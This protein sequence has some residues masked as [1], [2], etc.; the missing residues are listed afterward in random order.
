[1]LLTDVDERK[2]AED[3]LRESERELRLTV[4]SIPG[5]VAAHTPDGQ[6][7]FVNRQLLDYFGTTLEELRHWD[8]GGI[9]H[10]DD[11][12]RAVELFTHS[13][14]S[15]DPFD[16]EVRSRRFDGVYRWLQ[17]R[18]LAL[19][20]SN[21]HIVRW[22]NLLNDIDE[23]K[24]AEEAL[25]TN[26]RDLKLIIDTIPALSLVGA[27][28]WSRRLLQPA[29]SRIRRSACRTGDGWGWTAA[30]HPDDLNGLTAIWQQVLSSE[31]PGEAEARLRRHDGEYRWFLVRAKPLRDETGRVFKWYGIN[32]DIEDRKRTEEELRR[33]E[34][35]LAQGQRLTLTGSLWWEVSTGEVIWSEETFRIM[36]VPKSTKPTVELALS[37][38]HPEDVGLARQ[39]IER[40]APDGVNMDFELRLLMSDG[41]V[42]Y[43][44]VVLHNIGRQ[45]DKPEF[46]GALTDITERKRTEA[47]LRRAYDHLTEAQRLSQTGSFTTDLEEGRTPLVRRVLPHLRVRAR[48]D[49]LD[50]ETREIVHPE[51]VASLRG[52][53]RAR[54]GWHEPRFLFPH[55]D[56]ARRREAFS[57]LR[58]PDR[59][60]ARVHRRPSGRD[61]EQGRRGGA[62]QGPLRARTCG[63]GHDPERVDRL[64]RPRGNQPL[65]GIITNAGT[66]LRM[67]DADSSGRRRRARNR[68]AHD[69]RWQP[70]LGCDHAIARAVQQ[71]G[72]HAGA[73]GSERGHA[74][75][76]CA[77]VE[78]PSETPRDP[79]VGARRR[80]ADRHRRSCPAPAGHPEPAPQRRPTR[81]PACTIDREQLLIRTER[82][83]GDRVRLTVRDAGVGLTPR[84]WTSCLMPSTRRKAAAWASG[85][86]VSRSIIERHHGR[87]WAEPNDGP[88]ATFSFSIPPVQRAFGTGASIMAAERRSAI[89]RYQSLIDGRGAWRILSTETSVRARRRMRHLMVKRSL[90]S[91]VDDDESVRES[92][93]DLLRQF[94]F[95]AQAFS[96]AEAFLASEFVSRDQLSHSRRRD[97]RHVGPRPATGTGTPAAGRF[98][99]CSS[100]RTATR[101]SVRACWR[102][103]PS[104]ACSSRSARRRCSTRSMRRLRM[105]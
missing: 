26:E 76:H 48:S 36:D 78:R 5:L 99:L 81:W 34:A 88:G 87:L 57:W 92:L 75:G 28:R 90:V 89:T 71:D 19:R 80:S 37:R 51:D 104:S 63:E 49:D 58:A 56:L 91:V 86:S 17:S 95:A 83:D 2:R 68:A 66:C 25:A 30:I 13:I 42:K 73:A 53:D 93:P 40:S 94:G 3:A 41:S 98:R 43:V 69:S 8:T 21:G 44:H 7:E 33:S 103:G 54:H 39:I 46:I 96:S 9:T 12:P 64:D 100:P 45:P 38:V 102:R 101:R 77:V 74:R 59:R 15:G 60:T 16:F 70:R 32:I 65:S 20:D 6:V 14:E 97:A 11:L 18:G 67:L 55:R 27:H 24:R 10:P 52:R 47:E 4:D 50:A 85:L 35:F 72:I 61:R 22:Y 79:S 62:E 29:L 1:M 82:E 84:A 31:Q 105:R 23:R